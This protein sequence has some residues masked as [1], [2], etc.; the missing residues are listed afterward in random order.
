MYGLRS[1]A[2]LCLCGL[3]FEWEGLLEFRQYLVEEAGCVIPT[4]V[5]CYS[6]LLE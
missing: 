6:C 1:R 3:A 2:S 5:S 4:E